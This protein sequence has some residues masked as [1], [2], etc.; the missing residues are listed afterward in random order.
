MKWKL[1]CGEFERKVR[2]CFISG[3]CLLENSRDIYKR[4][5]ER[6]ALTIAVPM[7]KQ[8]GA[9]FTGDFQR[10]MKESSGN[11]ASFSPCGFCEG[12]LEGT[13]LYWEP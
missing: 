6:A 5:L 1:L 3:P 8:N 10:H 11:G 7:E 2:F 12:N 13:L 9:H 4:A